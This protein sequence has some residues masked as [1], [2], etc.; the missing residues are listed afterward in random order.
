M[1][2]S[3]IITE[4][5]SVAQEFARILGVSG[6]NDGY[7]ENDGY[8]ITWCVGHLV[9]MVYPEEYDERY[10]KWRLEDLPFLPRDYKYNVIPSVS[11]QYDVVHKMLHREDIDTV[12][13]AG[14]AGKEGQTI[15]ENIRNFGG[16]RDGMEELRVWIDSQTEEEIQRGI[17][18][19]K[20]MSAYEN[21]GKSGIMRTIEDYAMGINFSR[22]MSVK[23]GGLLNN[24][25]GTRSYTAIAVGRVMTC[26]LG[27]VVIR[28]R[29]IRNFKETPFYRVVGNFTDAHVQ[30]EWKAVEGSGYFASP[31]LYKENGFR[32]KKDALAL[33]DRV[34]GHPAI[35]ES[36]EKNISRK[37]APLLFNLAELQ[38]ECAKRFKI[39]PDETLQVAQ[40]L[41]E[42]K[43]TTYP[44]TDARVLS[45]PVAKE[46]HKNISRLR[47]YEPTSDFVEQ[48]LDRKLYGNIAGTQYT[49][50]SKVTDHYAIIPTGQLTELGKLNTLQKSVFD[51]I[52]RR[53]LSV[54]YPAAEYQNVKMTAVVD[55]G[56]KK[57]RFYASARVLKTPGYLE[58]AGIPKKEE[59]DSDPKEL[60]HL[61]DQL[62]KGDEISVDGYEVKEGKTSPPKRYTSG[63]MVLAMENAGQLIEDEELREQIKGSGIG[64]SATRAEII[65]KLVRI[66][67]LNLNK[68]TQVLTPEN[69]GEMVFE[70]VSMTVPALLNPKMTASWEKGLDG[71][72]RGTVDFW[73]YRTKLEDFIRRETVAMIEQDLTGQ[74]ATRIHPLVGKGGKGLAAKRSLGIPCPVCGG[75]IE[76]TPFGYGC[77]NYQKDGGGCRFSIGTI[78]GRDLNDEEVKELLTEGH[79]GVLSG[80]V[81]KSKKKFSA[82]LILEKDDEGK[83]SVGFDF[84]KNQP[85][86]LEG[87]VCPVCGSA[88][89][90]TPFGYSCVKHHEHPD[91]CYFS[92]GK[93]AGKALG[94]DDL[95]ELLTTGKT[96]LIRG[97]T[98]RNKK[99]FNACLKLEQTED[100][101]KNIAF[102]FSQNDAA[103]VPDVVCPICGGAIVETS[104][105][106]GCANYRQDAPDSCRFAIGTMAGKDLNAAQVKELLNQGRTGT[107][108]GFK[109]KSGKKF[110]ACIALERTEDGKIELRFDFEH[111]EA[112]KIKDVVCPICGGDIVATPFGFGC[113]NYVK[114]D[115]NSCRFSVG[116]MAEKALTEANVKELLTNGRTGTIRGFKSKSGKK[117]DA[118]VA[119]AKDEKGKVTGLKFDFTDLE[120]PKVKDVKCPVCGGDIVKTMFGYGCANYS[121]ENPDSCRFAIG[122]IAGVSL[123]EAQVKEL[124][125]RGK[126]DVIKGFVAKT[127]MKFDAPLKLTPEGQI[128]FDFPEKP[129]PVETTLA[130]PKCGKMLKKSQWYY[131][132]E[133][134]FKVS[135]TVAKVA[136]TE[137]VMRELL[138]T[139]KTKDKVTGFV[140]KAGNTFDTCLKLEDDRIV[141]DFDNP[142]T[143]R[144]GAS[145]GKGGERMFY[146]ELEENAQPQPLAAEDGAQYIEENVPP[147]YDAMAEEYAAYEEEE[148]KQQAAASNFLDEFPE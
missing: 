79:T 133:C 5:P 1:A 55:V 82:S 132:C 68:R 18:E 104:F 71:I 130:C 106:F 112:K 117:F 67:Y 56:E 101:R 116:K 27:M 63:S 49:D 8:V 123:K 40:D 28:E 84:S 15:E 43:L 120:A 100:G 54:F 66:H 77:S 11:R 34:Q 32:E 115:P 87:V 52:V 92:V 114:D 16:V 144:E 81:S 37:R 46:I 6:R 22:V 124:L 145:D 61:A 89:E 17:R 138:E 58:I 95:T 97:F 72:T 48:I 142:G 74:I 25:A 75:T 129:K 140:S 31:L 62:K 96:G 113:A 23:Y 33:I 3:L 148:A 109:S 29:E 88:V 98:A 102:D 12:Y 51:L 137:E 47:G 103:V 121:K 38:A 141:F 108:R 119:L 9:E 99:K 2:K 41:Y 20:P 146:E 65:K 14:D 122:K 90:I 44:R 35:V 80:F 39:S 86:I 60:L 94:V 10:K 69:L 30:G 78:A 19:A 143:K 105:G 107:I 36:I 73:D 45:T 59:E 126:T 64:T 139:G 110:D 76:T 85:E 53:F 24:A 111:V 134:G 26:V 147:F 125:L 13:W 4:K 118:R 42:R 93:I 135:H 21:L 50:D 91:E 7:I 70:V 57:E 131:E 127:G 136:L 128:A 83:V